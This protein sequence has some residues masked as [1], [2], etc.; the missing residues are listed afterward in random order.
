MPRKN[1]NVI[2]V[3]NYLEYDKYLLSAKD[4]ELEI[5]K[6]SRL[7]GWGDKYISDYAPNLGISYMGFM[8]L[9]KNN[10]KKYYLLE[11]GKIKTREYE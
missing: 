1:K 6:V 11:F 5:K 10:N 4:K 7:Q 2:W 3:R 8:T 9:D